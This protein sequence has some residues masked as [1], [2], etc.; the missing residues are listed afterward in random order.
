MKKY[1]VLKS[2]METPFKDFQMEIGKKYVCADFDRDP[3]KECSRGF[4]A[5]DI[6][7][8]TY[9][10]NEH[11]GSRVFECEVSGQSVIISQFKQRFET[12]ELIRELKRPEIRRLA[13]DA[14]PKLGYKL[15]EAIYPKNP[16][17]GRP[18]KVTEREIELLN[19]WIVVWASVGV[20][21]WALVWASVGDSVWDSVRA[22]VVRD[23]VR[24]SVVR[25]S[26]RASVRAY[27]SSLF[28]NIKKWWS[29][30]HPEGENPFQS[31]IDLWH[32]GFVPSFDGK[33][34]RLH[35]GKNADVVYEQVV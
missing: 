26:V 30:N 9:S 21:V 32:S 14:E 16:L 27:M 22:S 11:A 25:D 5:T 15:C 3:N 24:A 29:I 34:W 17:L 7:G 10:I 8:L 28:P 19:Q 18:K 13:R 1:K 4:Y 23:S 20:S 31:C 35:S 6:E 33:T 2:S 12:I